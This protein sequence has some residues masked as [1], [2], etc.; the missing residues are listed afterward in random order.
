MLRS[1]QGG[2]GEQG[3]TRTLA[4]CLILIRC[5]DN[6]MVPNSENTNLSSVHSDF[7]VPSISISI[8][9]SAS[10]LVMVEVLQKFSPV[11][12][13]ILRHFEVIC[14]KRNATREVETQF[15]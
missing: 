4:S 12:N 14:T 10:L 5:V 13:Y 11:K 1:V 9:S 2:G 15:K 6:I 8:S 3:A 7:S